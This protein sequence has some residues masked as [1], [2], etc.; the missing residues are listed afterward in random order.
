MTPKPPAI[1]PR[2]AR[3][4]QLRREMTSPERRLWGELR[5]RRCG[6]LKFRRQ[7]PIGPFVVDFYEAAHRLVLEVD[8]D[9]HNDRAELDR[10]R[11]DWLEARGLRVVRV[12]N[13]DVLRDVDAVVACIMKAVAS[14]GPAGTPPS[15]GPPGHLLPPGE[16]GGKHAPAATHRLDRGT[17]GGPR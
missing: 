17:K 8:G 4:R 15:S 16:K 9:S 14:P 6:S 10:A 7:V 12:S 2:V 1:A 11:Q 3:A 13:D 5:G